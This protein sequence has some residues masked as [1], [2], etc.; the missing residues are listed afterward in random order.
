MLDLNPEGYD[1]FRGE[2]ELTFSIQL[3]DSQA[4]TFGYIARIVDHKGENVDVIFNGPESNSLHVVFG[5]SLRSISVPGTAPEIYEKW[6]KLSLRYDIKNKIL[7]FQTPDTSIMQKEVD[8]SGKIKIFFGR[9]EFV[10]V[11]T[12]D[13]PRMNIKDIRLF[14]KNKCLHHFPLDELSGTEAKD[15]LS[16]RKARISN[17]DWIK[18]DYYQW[19]RS[20]ITYM[21]GM[22]AVCYEPVAEQLYLVGEDMLKI[23]SVLGDSIENIPYSTAFTDL[24]PGSQAFYDT[25]SNRLLCYSLRTRTMHYFDLTERQWMEISNGPDTP[26]RFWFHN[27]YFSAADSILYVF[28]GYSQHKYFNLIQQYKFSTGRWDTLVPGGDVFYPRMHAALGSY[29]DTLFMVGGFGSK[30]GDQILHP[31]HY[32]DLLA[33][34]L[35]EGKFKKK[36]DFQAPVADLDFANSMI[37]DE[38]DKSY[39]L[40]ATSIFE[41]DTYLQLYKGN[42]EDPKL[43]SLGDQIPYKYHNEYSYSDLFYSATSKELIAVTSLSDWEKNETDIL[44]YKIAFPPHATEAEIDE[45]WSPLWRLGTVIFLCLVLAATILLLIKKRKKKDES[46]GHPESFHTEFNLNAQTDGIHRQARKAANSIL[47]FG[48]FQVINK[49]GDDITKKFTPL[50]KELLLLIF[51]YSIKDKGISVPKLTEILWFSMDSKTAKNNRAVNIAKLKHLLA[52]IESCALS[53]NTSYWQLEFDDSVVY[54]D[55]W[56]CMQKINQEDLLSREDLLQFLAIVKAGPLLGN[57]AYEWLDEFKLEC[58]NL[59]IDKLWHS[60]DQQNIGSDPELMIQLADAVL[61]FDMMHEEAISK[62]CKALTALGKHSLAKEI[63][64]KFSKEYQSLY[65]EPFDRSFTELIKN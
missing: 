5:P 57:A 41:Y 1:A 13:V 28:G 61:I 62:K 64:E 20:F 50:L 22:V 9:N 23:Y 40:L 42:L 19:E 45:P 43:I 15:L 39:Y 52:E 54:N 6:M 32:T 36:Y 60:L 63:F 21:T 31:E 17:P 18:P 7:Q 37:I 53:R 47:F 29:A 34:S 11:Q 30:G 38:A 65:D 35:E 27:K 14:Q 33:F 3:R 12:T 44:V 2:F 10:P 55:Y 16:N 26:E 59:I 56:A 24:I 4:T 25:L 8:L 48:G 58:S 46:P 51:L 49:H